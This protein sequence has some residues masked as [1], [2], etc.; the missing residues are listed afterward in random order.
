MASRKAHKAERKTLSSL[1]NAFEALRHDL[2]PSDPWV[3]VEHLAWLLVLKIADDR[4]REAAI[5]YPEGLRWRDWATNSKRF[6]KSGLLSF[7]ENELIPGYQAWIPPS[8]HQERGVLFRTIFEG[9]ENRIGSDEVLRKV[10]DELGSLDLSF[11]QD[12]NVLGRIHDELIQWVRGEHKAFVASIL[13]AAVVR[14]AKPQWG[15]V[16]LD[17]CCGQGDLLVAVV[18]ELQRLPHE[19]NDLQKLN[20]NLHGYEKSFFDYLLTVLRLMLIGIDAP[21]GILWTK[22][23]TR[24]QQSITP[25]LQADVIV[26]N[27]PRNDLQ[28]LLGL[29]SNKTEHDLTS[30]Q[31]ALI[32]DH[33]LPRGRAAVVVPR[34]FLA[35]VTTSIAIKERLLG[36]CNLHRINRFGCRRAN[37]PF[38]FDA[39]VLLFDKTASTS[40][41]D[42]VEMNEYDSDHASRFNFA[43]NTTAD[44]IRSR[45]YRLDMTP[46]QLNQ[47]S[48]RARWLQLQS[49]RG[50]DKLHFELPE[51]GPTVFIGVNGSG[52]TSLLD[53]IAMQLSQFS[54]LLRNASVRHSE[55]QLSRND[56]RS[57]A[58]KAAIIALMQVDGFTETWQAST[59]AKP[60]ASTQVDPALVETTQFILEK[61]RHV[62]ASAIPVVCYYPATRGIGIGASG[63]KQVALTYPQLHAHDRAFGR[64]LGP[65]QDFV[66]WF[67]DEEDAENEKR[68]RKDPTYR[69]NKLEVVRRAVQGFLEALGGAHFANIRMER[70]EGG[71]GGKKIIELV[72]DKDST[73]LSIAQLSEGEKNTLLLVADLASRLGI[74][75]PEVANPLTGSGIVLIDEVDSHLHPAWQREVLPALEKTFSGCQFI[76]T[77]HS[78]Q[79]LGRVPKG[80]VFILENFD[81]IPKHPHTYG[82]DANSILGEVMGLPERPKDIEQL[83]HEASRLVD[84]EKLED[85]K[86]VLG[87][88][89]DAVGDTDH[90]VVRIRTMMSFLT[91]EGT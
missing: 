83:I 72:V 23:T 50:F 34:E 25:K 38:G 8:E 35:N 52:K 13:P 41:I 57:G 45:G 1:T 22:E 6:H 66:E 76:V 31:L 90:M 47:T 9:V 37:Q 36:E 55:L 48:L 40:E 12:Q 88:L 20:R 63:D 4:D 77:T 61:L 80:N 18:H 91:D 32:L 5:P 78:P 42:Y 68:L 24:N 59:S 62:P 87:K 86:L 27:L 2:R 69:S 79:V 26:S 29:A 82:R 73:R 3:A 10:L 71:R 60:K 64:G 43:W 74:A 84:E 39:D 17:V 49:F 28:R 7:L 46:P 51:H 30:N 14:A 16:I 89:A 56:V 70:L 53:A 58:E 75:N 11:T 15:E 21:S 67:R 54:A 65:F 33:L 81:I 19:P 85:A 44:A